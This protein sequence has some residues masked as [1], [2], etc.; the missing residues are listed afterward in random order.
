MKEK[1]VAW[2]DAAKVSR[3]K[4]AVSDQIIT[5]KTPVGDRPAQIIIGLG[6]SPYYAYRSA[7]GIP[8]PPT[9]ARPSSADVDRIRYWKPY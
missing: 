6:K 2:E 9:H 1:Y 8:I 3:S 5:V 4:L 7:N